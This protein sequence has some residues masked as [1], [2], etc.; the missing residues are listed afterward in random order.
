M[1]REAVDRVEQ[2]RTGANQQVNALLSGESDDIHSAIMAT[3]KAELSFELFLQVRNKV[4][5]AYQEVMRQ[6]I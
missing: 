4:V 1:F 6:Q 5:Q 2:F 3:Q